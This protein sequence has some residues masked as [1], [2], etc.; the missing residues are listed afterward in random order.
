MLNKITLVMSPRC[1]RFDCPAAGLFNLGMPAL[2]GISFWPWNIQEK[3]R[4]SIQEQKLAIWF[5]FKLS[6]PTSKLFNYY[7]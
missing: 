6:T 7:E 2:T 3:N 5:F 1:A 4:P